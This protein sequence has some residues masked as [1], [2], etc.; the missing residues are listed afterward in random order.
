MTIS[1]DS[2]DT[3]CGHDSHPNWRICPWCLDPANK[4]S[5]DDNPGYAGRFGTGGNSRN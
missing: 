4:D 1:A 5:C 3:S 2:N